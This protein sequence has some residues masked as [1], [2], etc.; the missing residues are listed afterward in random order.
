MTRRRAVAAGT[1]L[2][3]A[4]AVAAW[5]LAYPQAALTSTVVRTLADCAAVL[6]LGLATLPMLDDERHRGEV[7]GA[8]TAPLIVAA[9]CWVLAEL[10]RSI[11]VAAQAAAVPLS[12]LG[13]RSAVEVAMTTVPGRAGL[14]SV[15]TAAAV[16]ALVIALPRSTSTNVVV[17]GLAAV[18]VVSRQLTGHFADHAG[19]GLAVTVHTLAAA[20]W[21]GALAA[22]VLTVRHRGQWAR[23]LPRFSQ[24]SLVSVAVLVVAGAVGAAVRMGSVAELWTSGYGRVLA[25][26]IAMTVVLVAL[27]WRNRT[28]WLPAARAHRASADVSGGRSRIE[29]ALMVVALALAAGL[30]VTG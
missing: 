20:L 2:A 1:L 23:M 17:A 15:A 26:K 18:G 8:A 29:T 16:C 7:R 4:G 25:A 14:I 21:C 6:C 27:G 22:M 5:A 24:L 10:T 30:A 9:A 19:G 3:V 28:M 12:G 13:L 11:V